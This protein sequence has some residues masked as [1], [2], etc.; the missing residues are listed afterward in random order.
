MPLR[1]CRIA[2]FV[3]VAL[4]LPGAARAQVLNGTVEQRTFLNPVTQQPAAFNIYLPAG[5]AGGTQ[6]YPVVYHLHGLGGNQGSHNLP[7]PAS[8]EA[9]L[10]AQAIGPV[11][12]VFPS[13]YTDAWWADSIGGDKP[14]ETDVLQLIG[15]VDA[16]FR[17]IPFRGARVVQGFSMGGFGAT[18]FFS[19]FPEKF[20]ACIEYDGAFVTWPVMQLFS[21]AQAAAIFGNSEAYFND[22]SPW[23]WTEDHAG[24]LAGGNGVRMV[25]G[26]L[27]GGNR[28]FRDHLLD[29]SIPVNYIEAPCGH[30]LQCLLN[31]QGLA[32][33]SYFAARFDL[34]CAAA[35]ACY[36]DCDCSG[37]LSV[38]DFGCFQTKYVLGDAYADCNAD[39]AFSV[40]DFGCFQGKYV[41]GCP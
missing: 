35:A 5:Y 30:D 20:V 3:L 14:A 15:H 13:S 2:S 17:T 10:A 18:K 11:I 24:I 31:A 33:A 6:R 26:V 29:L 37:G 21:P 38:A 25:V 27:L 40:A 16:T 41:L 28:D 8:F 32:S 1:A 22:Y 23:R 4:I 7:V 34:P 12:I 39:L 9:A 19:K 36:A